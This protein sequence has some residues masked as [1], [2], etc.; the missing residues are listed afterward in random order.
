MMSTRLRMSACALAAGALPI[1]LWANSAGPDPRHTGAPGDQNCTAC[2]TGTALNSTAFAG[3]VEVTFPG[4]LTYTPGQTQRLRVTVTDNTARRWGFQLTAR[5]GSDESNGQAGTFNAINSN[6]WVQCSSV[7]GEGRATPKSPAQPCVNAFPLEFVQQ[8]LQGAQTGT[9][10]SASWEFEWIPPA[11]DVGTIKIHVAGNAT[12]G[13]SSPLGGGNGGDHVYTASY[14]LTPSA[15][16]PTGPRPAISQGGV[17]NA[18]QTPTPLRTIAPGAFFSIFG[19]NLST[20]TANWDAAF[21]PGGLAPRQL[22][23]VGVKVNGQDAFVAFVSPGQINAVAPDGLGQGDVSVTVT[24]GGGTSEIATVNSQRVSPAFFTYGENNRFYV[25]LGD[26]NA[27]RPGQEIALY[28]NG[29]GPTANN[30]PA[31]QIPPANSVLTPLPTVT[32]GGQPAT[33]TYAGL[34]QFVGVYQINVVVPQAA[35]NGDQE[36]RATVGGVQTPAGVF[37]KVQR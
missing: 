35:T 34:N 15:G 21:L 25:S 23:G 18:A 5:L 33:V 24:S 8:T 30:A 2:H 3:K 10:G 22:S 28:A 7:P 13:N 19:Q 29:F 20:A 4:G 6:A 37:L 11:S 31:G 17:I 9:A 1:L 32:I 36:I 16:G 12:N 26:T 27:R 14:T